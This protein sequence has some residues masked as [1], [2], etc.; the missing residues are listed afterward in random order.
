MT[1]IMN[2]R[3]SFMLLFICLTLCN[4]GSAIISLL[5]KA[6]CLIPN[7]S[8]HIAR[9]LLLQQCVS[10]KYGEGNET[11]C[12]DGLGCFPMEDPW[13]TI[14]R[15]FPSPYPP[16]DVDTEITLYT[17]KNPKGF[18]VTL[19]P[20]I[21]LDKSD[22]RARREATLFL[23]HGFASNGRVDWLMDMKD[24]I[25]NNVD[26]NVFVVDWEKGSSVCNYLQ[27]AS[28]TRIVGAELVRL[29][30]HLLKD[31]LTT[32][33][34][35][36]IGHSLG[37]HIMGYLGKG[38][39]DKSRIVRR[40]TALDPA[41]PG[42]EG[43]SEEVRLNKEDAQYVD[44]IHTDAKPFLPFIGFG[45]IHPVGDVDFYMNGGSHQP[46]CY[47]VDVKNVSSISDLAKIPVEMVSQWV[48]CS[49][50]RSYKY[51]TWALKL[52]N[53]SM[54]GIKLSDTETFFKVTSLGTLG[55]PHPVLKSLEECDDNS[56][57]VLGLDTFKLKA[58]GVFS[59]STKSEDPFC[60][61]PAE[62]ARKLKNL[63]TGGLY[64][65]LTG[66]LHRISSFVKNK[67]N[68]IKNGA[69]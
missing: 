41:Q 9:A 5:R 51:F 49:H 47:S 6:K 30:K 62:N 22:Y 68:Y 8:D 53:C 57:T 52:R 2:K 11:A 64:D 55:I 63:V 66:A 26:A 10:E 1:L 20:N 16:E 69:S 18:N 14:L 23:T 4:E 21:S 67:F 25:L 59:V 13:V 15:P 33:R 36:L 31:G 29:A 12:Y 42:F 44:V 32:S 3:C 39:K 54:W 24:A 65:K 28:N 35:H 61:T 27:A 58:R 34:M 17:R 7:G 46:G 56:C 43:S 38:V 37:A 45:M 60:E 19:W 48:S 50:G 40:I